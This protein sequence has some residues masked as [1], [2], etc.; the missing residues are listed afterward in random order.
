MSAMFRRRF[1][2]SSNTCSMYS[3]HALHRSHRLLCTTLQLKAQPTTC[4]KSS[5]RAHR[6]SMLARSMFTFSASWAPGLTSSPVLL[7][8]LP[9]RRDDVPA[10]VNAKASLKFAL[11][12]PTC[13][14]TNLKYRSARLA[15]CSRS[16]D[17]ARVVREGCT[18]SVA[19]RARCCEGGTNAADR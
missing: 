9:P 6:L 2:S 16:A 4:Q 14:W 7:R 5:A 18:A 1:Q 15:A 3:S 17:L 10:L 11:M 12:G 19:A 13:W 8:A